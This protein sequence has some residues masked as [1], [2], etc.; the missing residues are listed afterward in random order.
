MG[1]E[2]VI[3]AVESDPDVVEFLKTPLSEL[4]LDFSNVPSMEQV[5]KAVRDQ[6]EDG[7]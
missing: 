3:F 4:K 1:D 2:K 7:Q 5:A 6:L